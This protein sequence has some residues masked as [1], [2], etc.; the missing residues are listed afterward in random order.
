MNKQIMVWS[1]VVILVG[2]GAFFGGRKSENNSL[3]SH[4]LIR[5]AGG[6]VSGFNG[7][8]VNGRAGAN[9]PGGP[10][11]MAGGDVTSGD[12]A[13]KDATSITLKTRD[14]SSKIVFV[15]GS[16]AV[17]KSAPGSLGDLSVGQSVMVTGKTNPD[18][19]I[20]AQN[21]QVRPTQQPGQPQ[22]QKGQ[23]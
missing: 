20:T 19:S 1:L 7:P 14:G 8:G 3:S 5:G 2:V 18:G 16:T 4:G 23:Q 21:V 12:V 6:N 15:S 10:V 11:G 13:A 17:A 22:N 9:R